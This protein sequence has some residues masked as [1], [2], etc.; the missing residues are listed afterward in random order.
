VADKGE[1]TDPIEA[2]R[3]GAS[4]P[5]G[6]LVVALSGGADSAVCAWLA[7]DAGSKVRAIF[8]DH[9][10]EESP[11]LAMAARNI[12]ARLEIDLDEIPVVVPSGPSPEGQAR[13][14]RHAA[15]EEALKPGEVLLSGHTA[16]DQAE[17]VLGNLL[18]GAGATGLAGIPRSRTRWARPLLS[19]SRGNVRAAADA[20]MLPYVDDPANESI[21]PRRNQL[22]HEV[23]PLLR[24]RFNPE[25][26]AAL[27]RTAELAA[28][29]DDVLEQRAATVPVVSTPYAVKVPAAALATTPLAVASRIARR[30]I[31]VARGDYPGDAIEVGAVVAAAAGVSTTIA[32]PLQVE[33]E[34]PWVVL[35]S[36]TEEA[37]EAVQ[38][39]VP[40]ETTFWAGSV[41]AKEG[42]APWQPLGA[43]VVV[44]DA[45]VPLIVRPVATGDRIEIASGH[46]KVIAVLAEAKV[47]P[48]SRQHWPVVEAGG[49]IVW[50]VGVRG[51]AAEGS[52]PV[53][54][55]ATLEEQ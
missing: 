21:E 52:H 36:P 34:G 46:K 7:R 33:R 38:L 44:L 26:T 53:T 4:V 51:S 32:G 14:V 9:G 22:R 19:V 29:D 11:A 35:A 13:S 24:E 17:T 47:P 27:S 1:L 48:R 23:L 30:A 55:T 31:R 42:R 28:A 5:S 20:L 49:T 39:S 37:P 12:A 50:V 16:D 25:L 8:V 10:F 3:A 41:V 43:G 54:L 15:L 2:V 18:R 6:P 40:G 45:A